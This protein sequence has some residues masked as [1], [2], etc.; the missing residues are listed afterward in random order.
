MQTQ[1]T[2]KFQELDFPDS[3]IVSGNNLPFRTQVSKLWPFLTG[4]CEHV[5]NSK[6]TALDLRTFH[7]KNITKL[8]F[9]VGLSAHLLIY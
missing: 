4:Y 8:C 2:W 1:S 7:C 6:I 9:L 3:F 5:K